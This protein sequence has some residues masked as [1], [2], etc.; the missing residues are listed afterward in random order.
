MV[1]EWYGYYNQIDCFPSIWEYRIYV[2]KT[3]TNSTEISVS[4]FFY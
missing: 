1:D 4:M 2:G 3:E